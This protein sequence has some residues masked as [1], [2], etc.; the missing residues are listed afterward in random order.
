MLGRSTRKGTSDED[1]VLLFVSG[2]DGHPRFSAWA[3][4]AEALV[5]RRPLSV[6]CQA[7]GAKA[8]SGA[9]RQAVAEQG[10]G[11]EPGLSEADAPE[12]SDSGDDG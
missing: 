2:G 8:L 3:D 12:A 4:R 6:P 7:M 11:H 1:P 9:A 10:A 5:L